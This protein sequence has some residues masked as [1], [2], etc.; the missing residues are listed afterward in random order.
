MEGGVVRFEAAVEREPAQEV[1]V[2]SLGHAGGRHVNVCL[3]DVGVVKLQTVER[4]AIRPVGRWLGDHAQRREAGL[5]ENGGVVHEAAEVIGE[6]D[7]PVG[8]VSCDV[9]HQRFECWGQG[10][11]ENEVEFRVQLLQ[12]GQVQDAAGRG[13]DAGPRFTGRYHLGGMR[14]RGV[15]GRTVSHPWHGLPV[16]DGGDEV[17]VARRDEEAED[18][19]RIREL[20]VDD[21]LRRQL[22]R[23]HLV[24]FHVDGLEGRHRTGN[25]QQREQHHGDVGATLPGQEPRCDA[26]VATAHVPKAGL[27]P[28]EGMYQLPFLSITKHFIFEFF[29]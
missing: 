10:V 2:G 22:R 5:R 11:L 14:Q 26:V 20:L 25:H 9:V 29:K 27:P 6:R 21:G 23:F 15:I 24:R 1:V 13:V 18:D 3:C 7:G 16:L 19:L 12:D 17:G 4:K 8:L 28:F